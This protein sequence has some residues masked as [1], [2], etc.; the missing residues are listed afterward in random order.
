[1][2][3]KDLL[4]AIGDIDDKYLLEQNKTN[5]F[6]KIK[7]TIK[8]SMLKYIL[9]PACIIIVAIIGTFGSKLFTNQN[10]WIIKKVQIN[11]SNSTEDG[12]AIIPKWEEMSISQQFNELEYKNNKYSSRITQISKEKILEKVG[13]Y[14]LKGYDTYSKTT[15]HK[16]G[17]IYS[18]KNIADKCAVA[19]KFEEDSNYYVYVNSYYRPKTLGEFMKDLNLKEITYFGTIYYNY[20]DIN[21]QENI[22]IEFYNVDNNIIW[23]KLFND[24]SLENIYSDTDIAK[25]T[26]EK[27]CQNIGISVDIPILGYK[28]ISI[29]LT[30]KGY[31]LTNILDTGKGFY[32]GKEKVQEFL[33]YIKENYIGYKIV[34]VNENENNI[35][36]ENKI[37]IPEKIVTVENNI[38]NNTISSNIVTTNTNRIESQEYGTSTN[39]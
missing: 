34:Y 21:K 16:K 5:I 26:S 36:K 14:T 28:N 39:R 22:N 23:Q 13:N 17:E 25:Y 9:A 35:N 15:Y 3:N 8:N 6:N 2:N 1:M 24:L 29:S 11:N 33:D 30:D 18:I 20:W 38:G 4:R 37:D 32:I 27:I 31:L 10:D 19:V 12:I 7:I